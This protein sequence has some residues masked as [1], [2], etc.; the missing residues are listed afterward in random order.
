MRTATKMEK[1][2]DENYQRDSGWWHSMVVRLFRRHINLVAKIAT[3]RAFERSQISSEAMH[4]VDGIID[5]MLW[6]TD[7]YYDSRIVQKGNIVGG[8]MAG[9]DINK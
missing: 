5:R 7:K 1:Q 3:S 4:N 9:G 8:D 6:P 2:L